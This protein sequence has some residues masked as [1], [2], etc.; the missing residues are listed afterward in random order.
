MGGTLKFQNSEYEVH[1][2]GPKDSG[3]QNFSFLALKAKPVG[4]VQILRT[5]TAMARDR[6]NCFSA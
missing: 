4:E 6:R 5:A 2:E 1:Q 3:S